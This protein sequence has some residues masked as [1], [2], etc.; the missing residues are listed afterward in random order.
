MKSF[1]ALVFLLLFF[2]GC[3]EPLQKPVVK[4]VEFIRIKAL[5]TQKCTVCHSA[6]PK[7]N[8]VGH[9]DVLFDTDEQIKAKADR[10]YFRVV[11]QKSMP[12]G[13]K[14]KITEEERDLI[15][16]WHSASESIATGTISEDGHDHTFAPA[17]LKILNERCIVCHSLG[18]IL[19]RHDDDRPKWTRTIE[20]MRLYGAVLNDGEAEALIDYLTEVPKADTTD[21]VIRKV[22]TFGKN[23]AWT[24]D[25]V[26]RTISAIDIDKGITVGTISGL[27]NPHNIVMS[28]DGERIIVT[29]PGNEE[30]L[31]FATADG[32]LLG[33]LKGGY[34]PIHAFTSP[35]RKLI[36]VVNQNSNDATVYDY[37]TF[38][39]VA[40]LPVGNMPHAFN[41]SP[42]SHYA[43]VANQASDDITVIDLEK[44]TSVTDIKAAKVPVAAIVNPTNDFV[45]VSLLRSGK[46][47]KIDT[48]THQITGSV[49]VE[50]IPGQVAISP[51]NKWAISG[52]Q[53]TD[54]I[55]FIDVATMEVKNTIRTGKWAHGLAITPDYKHCLVTNQEDSTVSV[56][57]IETQK[58]IKLIPVGLGPNNIAAAYAGSNK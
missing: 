47:I 24:S 57:D 10:I 3:K 40:T 41:I 54:T 30:S 35:N 2:T 48:K 49:N 31:V 15:A 43:Y 7:D 18:R 45:L 44:M 22:G 50:G 25:E 1:T 38:A 51:D 6:N 17:P 12:F 39:Q 42:D 28:S 13:N 5:I 52:N 21:P 14:T 34:T 46:L 8:S 55:S 27:H 29:D 58:I 33:H 23:L 56:I 11:E 32:S 9:G 16:D 36:V 20:K 4:P 37:N 26:G 19:N 53:N